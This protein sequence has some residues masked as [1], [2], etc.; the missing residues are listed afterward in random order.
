M[1]AGKGSNST[2]A[3]L[4]LEQADEGLCSQSKSKKKQKEGKER[5]ERKRKRKRK[6]KKKTKRFLLHFLD[7]IVAGTFPHRG[8]VLTCRSQRQPGRS[9]K[10]G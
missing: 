9:G 4:L 8:T 3:R 10:R 7:W 1:R 6:Q 2:K 5:R